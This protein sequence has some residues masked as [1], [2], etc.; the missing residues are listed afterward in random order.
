MK[1]CLLVTE[2]F[3]SGYIVYAASESP[4]YYVGSIGIPCGNG[5]FIS[6]KI[7]V[8]E[9]DKASILRRP[10]PPYARTLHG[11]GCGWEVVP[12]T[13]EKDETKYKYKAASEFLGGGE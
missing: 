4:I 13:W 3:Y 12:A 9:I 2:E 10:I 11:E 1:V 7:R 8:I 5:Q 6:G